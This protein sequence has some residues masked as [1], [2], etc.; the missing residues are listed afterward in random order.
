MKLQTHT[1]LA[2]A[3]LATLPLAP[4]SHAT[5]APASAPSSA[6]PPSSALNVLV[7]VIDDMGTD[8]L[9]MYGTDTGP[10]SNCTQT[11]VNSTPTPTLDILRHTGIRFAR[12]YVNPL[13]SPTRAAILT[14]RYGMRTGVGAAIDARGLNYTLPSSE[15]FLP[16]LIRDYNTRSYA[17][18]AFGKWHV[19]DID[20]QDAHPAQNGFEIYQGAKGNLTSH[21]A[22]RKVT[23]TGGDSPASAVSTSQNIAPPA[24]A[25][26]SEDTYDAS[27]NRRD[28][29]AWINQQ[30][31]PFF[32]YVCFNPPHLPFQVP[33]MTLL[34]KKTR[35]K[36]ASLGYETGEIP[37]PSHAD[38][39]LLYHAGI[40]A[41]DREIGELLLSIAPKLPRTMI[42]V[43]GDNGTP[44]ESVEDVTM[45]TQ[46]KRSMYE[47][48]SRVPM[49]VNGP[50]AI[51]HAGQTCRSI[52]SGVDLWRT[53]AN[54]TGMS[55]STIDTAVA[56]Q[57]VPNDSLSLMGLVEDP[58]SAGPR[59]FAYS[60]LFPN[61]PPPIPPN[62]SWLRAMSDGNYRYVRRR[63][64]GV[65]TEELYDLAADPCN[66]DD[67]L[68]PPHVLAP[69][70]SAARAAM[71]AAMDAL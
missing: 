42:V 27:V 48:G 19:A 67:L 69:A 28:A 30:T 68:K 39:S 26:P 49:L 54:F 41:I 53:V 10:P 59:A 14:G 60:E 47:M 24:G 43:L 25:A 5:A 12:A 31:K 2:V 16:E 65:I 20:T 6:S 34:S 9:A 44:V 1:A 51:R 46:V 70:E 64:G 22:W 17:R 55:N 38:S 58:Q 21:F 57:G 18:G 52:V 61:G 66:V 63:L 7:V 33:P 37:G 3:C 29:T 62:V 15:L 13:C 32:A 4:I 36:L 45:G 23:A 71:S 40:E 56:A 50:L 8:Q 11:Q 35:A